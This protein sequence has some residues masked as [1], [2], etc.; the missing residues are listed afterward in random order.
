MSDSNTT[1]PTQETVSQLEDFSM[2]LLACT[3]TNYICTDSCFVYFISS[4]YLTDHSHVL[5]K[6]QFV[7]TQPWTTRSLH[8]LF[9]CLLFPRQRLQLAQN[10]WSRQSALALK[11]RV[12]EQE[13]LEVFYARDAY[14]WEVIFLFHTRAPDAYWIQ[15]FC[16]KRDKRTYCNW[17][18]LAITILLSHPAV[19]LCFFAEE[20]YI[21]ELYVDTVLLPLSEQCYLTDCMQVNILAAL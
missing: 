17:Q 11:S 2:P 9:P 4:S 16:P 7:L 20:C 14:S 12:E 19:L 10:G 21:F 15:A 6:E 5:L 13:N 3:S 1:L 8:L 18:L